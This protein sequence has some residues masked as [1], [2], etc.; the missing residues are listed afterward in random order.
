MSCYSCST[1]AFTCNKSSFSALPDCSCALT[2][3]TP[4][5]PA[6]Y[7]NLYCGTYCL[8]VVCS[9]PSPNHGIS[10]NAYNGYHPPVCVT[11]PGHN[12]SCPSCPVPC[13]NDTCH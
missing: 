8:P 5:T 12:P 9:K 6:H 4:P 1:A 7:F 13:P 2:S 3:L 10:T 11:L